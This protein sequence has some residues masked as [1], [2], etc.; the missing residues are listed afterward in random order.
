MAFDRPA[1]RA[2]SA[3]LFAAAEAPM[4]RSGTWRFTWRLGEQ[5][6]ERELELSF[7]PDGGIAHPLMAADAEPADNAWGA[8][9]AAFGGACGPQLPDAR[10]GFG[11][12]RYRMRLR[13]DDEMEGTVAIMVNFRRI[14]VAAA[15]RWVAAG[16]LA[17]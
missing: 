10:L 12:D 16:K 1:E 17:R 5:T 3:A 9:T 14:E 11:C 7:R 4:P 8:G 13:S 2:T 15:G 6:I